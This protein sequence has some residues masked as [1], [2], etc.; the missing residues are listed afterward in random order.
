MRTNRRKLGDQPV[1]DIPQCRR[2]TEDEENES[3]R[4]A[5]KAANYHVEH[6]DVVD[7][8]LL[9]IP[10]VLKIRLS[11]NFLVVS[12]RMT[13]FLL[14]K[15][16]RIFSNQFIQGSKPTK[17][18]D[19]KKS[20]NITRTKACTREVIEP[21][22]SLCPGMTALLLHKPSKKLSSRKIQEDAFF[23]V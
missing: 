16:D 3:I 13:V 14:I 17:S 12:T 2:P 20:K 1:S 23:F 18:V 15:S 4:E 11:F 21:V 22:A 10:V 6:D 19:L 9:P 5:A 7:I 8:V